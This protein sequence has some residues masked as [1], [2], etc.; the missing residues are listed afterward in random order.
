MSAF[1][2]PVTDTNMLR[3]CYNFT[4][5]IAHT[6]VIVQ[7]LTNADTGDDKKLNE[8]RVNI[9]AQDVCRKMWGDYIL[10]SQICLGLGD[11]GACN[12]RTHVSDLC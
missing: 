9:T 6:H 7:S 12:V 1:E 10:D 5:T 11:V 2:I 8:L 4:L 3:R